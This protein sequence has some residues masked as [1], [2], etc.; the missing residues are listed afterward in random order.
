MRSFCLASIKR[1]QLSS[2]EKSRNHNQDLSEQSTSRP[3]ELYYSGSTASLIG[4]ISF[5]IDFNSTVGIIADWRKKPFGYLHTNG[6]IRPSVAA[7]L[8]SLNTGVAKNAARAA[9]RLQIK[10]IRTYRAKD[11]IINYAPYL[12]GYTI[13]SFFNR[14]GTAGFVDIHIA[15]SHFYS[16]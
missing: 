15:C 12:S 14:M 5:A 13:I 3:R 10:N 11:L 7:P 16:S 9:V 2:R 8:D 1:C 6:N 4:L